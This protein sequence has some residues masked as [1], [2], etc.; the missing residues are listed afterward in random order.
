MKKALL[1]LAV[2]VPFTSFSIWVTLEKGYF[3]FIDLALREPWGA[4]LFIDLAISLFFFAT[5]MRRD[6]REHGI[7]AWPYL[8]GLPLLGSITALVYLI[9]R[10][11][12]SQ[13][14]P[15]RSMGSAAAT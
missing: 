14:Q 3:G 6:A 8:I 11:L 15:A 12:A 5:W 10:A 9:H 7:P 2:L 13:G 1:P 4:Q